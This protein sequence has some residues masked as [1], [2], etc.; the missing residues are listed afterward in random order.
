MSRRVEPGACRRRRERRRTPVARG[1]RHRGPPPA[2]P[3]RR[4]R[5]QPRPCRSPRSLRRSRAGSCRRAF[6]CASKSR[7]RRRPRRRRCSRGAPSCRSSRA[8][9][10]P[11]RARP[12][13]RSGRPAPG[14]PRPAY[15]SA[16]RPAAGHDARDDWRAATAAVAAGAADEPAAAAGRLSAAAGYAAAPGRG[17]YHRPQAAGLPVRG[18]RPRREAPASRPAPTPTELPPVS[19]TIT[20]AE[21]MTVKDLADKL[22]VRVKDV[23]K[24]LL[25]RRMMMTINS[26]IDMDTAREVSRQF[27][28]DVQ[29]RSFEEELHRGRVGSRRRRGSGRARAGRDRHGSRRSR[30]DDAAR[31]DP[32][33]ARRRA[34]GRRHHA[35]H[36]RV[37]RAGRREDATSTSSSST[38]PATKR[39]R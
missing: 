26:T 13:R 35:A 7:A 12:R 1:S 36:R 11:R 4:C 18:R 8:S 27:G 22:D 38:R 39:S 19:R 34:R 33:D 28:A 20:L 2:H 24:S 16:A 6:A 23:L 32:H 37:S 9:R 14:A 31:L 10:R 15:P 25:D 3:K 5:K 21:G 30:Q 29:T 17:A